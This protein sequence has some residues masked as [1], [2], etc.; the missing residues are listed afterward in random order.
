MQDLLKFITE[1]LPGKMQH[2]MMSI[3]SATGLVVGYIFDGLNQAFY[4]LCIFVLIDY[5]TGLV[6]AYHNK[7][8]S[9]KVGFRG[10]VKKAIIL[11]IVILFHGL[12]K[13]VE[14][15]ALETSA[16][17]AFCLNEMLSILENIERAGFG[18]IVPPGVRQLLE[19]VQ[20]KTT[21]ELKKNLKK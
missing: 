14:F 17:F 3:G 20:T 21:D 7:N 12:A 2:I 16:I 4:W 5:I 18:G 13:I 11:S 8:L 15:P 10:I 9:S 6:Q 1:L 19:I